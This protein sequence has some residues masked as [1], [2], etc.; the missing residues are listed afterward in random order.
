MFAAGQRR[1][2]RAHGAV[3]AAIVTPRRDGG[4]GDGQGRTVL[5]VSDGI[6]LAVAVRDQVDR[7]YVTVRDV[8]PSDGA[9]AIRACRPW[10][11]MVI[12]DIPAVSETVAEALG[13]HPLLLFWCGAMP[14]GLPAHA[15]GFARF[16]V[17]AAALRMALGASVAGIRLAPGGG[18]TMPDGIHA[19]NAALEALVASHPHPVVAPMR[20]FRGALAA[21]TAH[22]VPLCLRREGDGSVRLV[23]ARGA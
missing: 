6:E 10:P 5:V 2:H 17:M 15:R 21:I 19:G 8:P 7:A 13:E 14:A 18:L 9:T 11:W 3:G 1:Y 23:A 22:R 16:S 4:R 12:G 20:D